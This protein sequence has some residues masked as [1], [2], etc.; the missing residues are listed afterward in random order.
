MTARSYRAEMG[1]DTGIAVLT[2]YFKDEFVRAFAT[3]SFKRF[4]SAI[5]GNA[6]DEDFPSRFLRDWMSVVC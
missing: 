2:A 6:H 5:D 4:L 3:S 1:F